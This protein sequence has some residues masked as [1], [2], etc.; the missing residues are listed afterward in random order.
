MKKNELATHDN[1]NECQNVEQKKQ[2]QRNAYGM[3]P[4]KSSVKKWDAELVFE[5]YIYGW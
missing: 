2:E 3:I 1:V 4:F 5:G